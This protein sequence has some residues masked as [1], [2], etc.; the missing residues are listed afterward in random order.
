MS[1]SLSLSQSR[2]LNTTK[3][4]KRE[5][6]IKGQDRLQELEDRSEASKAK[7]MPGTTAAGDVERPATRNLDRD[8]K[9]E[10]RP[11][12]VDTPTSGPGSRDER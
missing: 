12:G 8:V 5:A 4:A 9:M 10:S 3:T 11:T 6:D 2:N 1:L 7:N